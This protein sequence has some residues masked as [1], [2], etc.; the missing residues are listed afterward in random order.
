MNTKLVSGVAA[1]VV[2]AAAG[3]YWTSDDS[4]PAV[5]IPEVRLPQVDVP[6]VA[7]AQ[8][9][10][11]SVSNPLIEPRGTST[12]AS[13][14]IPVPSVS[15][16]LIEP[17]GMS[18]AAAVEPI[19]PAVVVPRNPAAR[20]AEIQSFQAVCRKNFRDARA[21]R[22]FSID[23]PI[24]AAWIDIYRQSFT[25]KI[26]R[27]PLSPNVHMIAEIHAPINFAVLEKNLSW[28]RTKG[29]NSVLITWG[30]PGE[31]MADLVKAASVA[32]QKNLSVYIALSGPENQSVYRDPELL[33]SELQILGRTADGF[34]VGWRRTSQ[35]LWEKD[36]PYLTY[37]VQCIRS[38]NPTIAIIGE[39]Y[40]GE[41]ARSSRDWSI[42]AP[43]YVSGVILSGLS[44][45]GIAV[46]KVMSRLHSRGPIIPVVLGDRAFYLKMIPNGKSPLENFEVKRQ[47]V[48][49]W[50]A[51]GAAGVIVLHGDGEENQDNLAGRIWDMS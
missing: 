12:A 5:D 18:M 48:R 11:P 41:T 32:K 14:Q 45:R 47:M 16:P 8:I 43:E 19:D 17:R 15:D 3:V 9:P 31:D 39:V 49:R 7:L 20:I 34:L 51:A 50:L 30:Y 10:V 38:V 42:E 22:H 2:A 21:I 33:R 13:V 36:E 35:H 26:D 23:D 29:F 40:F 1:A 4:L 25:Q 46:E 27:V 24:A 37:M 28:Y 44:T 6:K